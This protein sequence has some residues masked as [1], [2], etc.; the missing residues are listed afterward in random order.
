[1]GAD[2]VSSTAGRPCTHIS[3]DGRS[4]PHLKPCPVHPERDRN[5]P[6]SRDRDPKAHARFARALRQR[7]GGTCERCHHQPAQVAHHVKPGYD[8]SCGLDL[9]DDCHRAVDTHA[10]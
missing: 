10:R 9:C 7:S 3:R 1:M 8:A 6:W 4:C 2:Q 5:A